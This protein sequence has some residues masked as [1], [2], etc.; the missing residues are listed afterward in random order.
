LIWEVP[1]DLSVGM[2]VSVYPDPDLYE[3]CCEFNTQSYVSRFGGEIVEGVYVL[4]HSDLPVY[5]FVRHFIV[6]DGLDFIDVTPFADGRGHNWF[7]EKKISSYNIFKR[8]LNDEM[9]ENN[10]FYYV[11]CYLDPHTKSPFYVGKGKKDRAYTH[12]MNIR[13]TNANKNKTRFKNKIEKLKREGMQPEII[14]LA[15]NITDETIAYE[16]EEQFIR[17]YGRAGYDPAGIL[18]NICENSRPPN[19]KGRSYSEIYGDAWKEQVEK[20]RLIQIERGGFGPKH[21]RDSTKLK[22]QETSIGNANG[23]SSKL[24]EADILLHGKEFCDYF[25]GRISSTK[26]KWWCETRR[27]P[28][29]RKTF[30]FDRKPIFEVFKEEYG[31]VITND[32]FSWFHDPT[33]GKAWRCFD[34]EL[35]AKNPPSG[36]IR[37]RGT[38]NRKGTP[39]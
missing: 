6:K 17:K 27:I 28:T 25:S 11:Y 24:T 3:N 30:R 39:L 37:G 7:I 8:G 12:L 14:F 9:N 38:R 26:W 20:R 33:T 13:A 19:H 34:W 21:H 29:L 2:A 15:Q 35:D 22:I 10:D 18:L 5:Q 23:N 36:F 32:S 16:I 31:A 1:L 4:R